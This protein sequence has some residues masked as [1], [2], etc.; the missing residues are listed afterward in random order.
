MKAIIK[1]VGKEPRIIEIEN[2]LK[3]LQS[4]VE[5]Y[6]ETISLPGNIILICNEEGKL[7]NMPHNFSLNCD[8]IVGPVLFVSFNGID[9]FTDLSE[10]QIEI[11]MRTFKKKAT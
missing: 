4:L 2:T 9:S 3:T 7:K 11:V 1:E 8:V 5:G 6:I 10:E